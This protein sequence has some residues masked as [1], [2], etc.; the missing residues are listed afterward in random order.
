MLLILIILSSFYTLNSF[1]QT[2]G[3]VDINR[4]LPTFPYDT[5]I[6]NSGQDTIIAGLTD[7]HFINDSKGWINSSFVFEQIYPNPFNLSTK[8]KFAISDV[9]ITMLKIYD[10]LGNEVTTLVNEELPADEYEVEFS[11]IGGS[12]FGGNDYILPSGIYFYR[13]QAGNFVETKKMVLMK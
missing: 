3:W 2:Y 7:A 11:A 6:I 10:V 12:A 4:N 13:L 1:A 9:R 5:T 8:I